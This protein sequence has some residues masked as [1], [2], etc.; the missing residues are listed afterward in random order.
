MQSSHIRI[1]YVAGRGFLLLNL[2]GRVRLAAA[3]AAARGCILTNLVASSSE[4]CSPFVDT[5][6][7]FSLKCP[8]ILLV[9][10]SPTYVRPIWI[11]VI[12]MIKKDGMVRR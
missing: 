8:I 6:A 11:E 5:I 3:A 7:V 12:V 4:N 9:N 10:A 1:T 2:E